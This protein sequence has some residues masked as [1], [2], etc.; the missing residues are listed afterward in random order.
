MLVALNPRFAYRIFKDAAG[1]HR[2]FKDS[3]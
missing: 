1:N 3:L 2:A